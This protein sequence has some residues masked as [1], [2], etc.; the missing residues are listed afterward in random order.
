MDYKYYLVAS[1][2][3]QNLVKAFSTS[4]VLRFMWF[5]FNISSEDIEVIYMKLPSEA[6]EMTNYYMWDATQM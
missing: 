1:S 6:A 5:H 4:Q 3:G 2:Q